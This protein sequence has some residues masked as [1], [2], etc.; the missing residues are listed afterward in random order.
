MEADPH[1]KRRI[2]NPGAMIRVETRSALFF[3]QSMAKARA[4]APP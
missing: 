2:D 1:S 4:D 3:D